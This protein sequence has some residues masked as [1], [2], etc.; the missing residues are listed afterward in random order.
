MNTQ[1]RTRYFFYLTGK[2]QNTYFEIGDKK[3]LVDG[4]S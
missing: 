2:G 3:Y 1:T 4:L